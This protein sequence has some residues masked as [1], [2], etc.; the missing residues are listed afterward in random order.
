MNQTISNGVKILYIITQAD[1]GGAQKYTLTLAK[2]FGGAVAAGQQDS[3]LFY[4][5]RAAGLETFP[6]KYLKRTINPWYDL[7]AVWEIRQLI[8]FYQPNIVHLNSSK[9]GVVGSFAGI[10]LKTKVVYTAHGFIF[11]EPLPWV[12]KSFYLA[13]E[14]VASD[15]RD[16]IICVSEA[17]KK[18][19]LDN[20]LISGDKISTIHNGLENVEF[21]P[22]KEARQALNLST[23]D[24]MI[25]GCVANFYKTKGVD[26]LI[27][28]ISM[29]S[30]ETKTKILLAIIGEGEESLNLKSKILRLNLSKTIS[31]LGKIDNA[32]HKLKAFDLLVIAS[33]KE[34]LPFLLLEAMQAGLPIVATNVGGIREALGDAG[35]LISSENPK[36]ITSAIMTLLLDSNRAS[37]LSAK[38]SERSKL[39]TVEKM[40]GETKKI[41]AKLLL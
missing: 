38:A 13:L 14:K 6:L 16:Y 41:Y 31:L 10:G 19:A 33:R 20:K 27:E 8:K 3:K 28:A 23:D 32:G 36:A 7:L 29:L 24:R 40:L 11:N 18:S 17:D 4:E 37:E 34:G 22:K 1:G 15:F 2:H 12:I 21:L 9:A 25:I 30:D 39:F 26:V 5:A 35:I